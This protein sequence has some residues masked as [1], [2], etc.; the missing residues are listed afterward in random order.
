[1]CRY[2]WLMCLD[3]ALAKTVNP[4][5]RDWEIAIF[6]MNINCAGYGAWCKAVCSVSVS[7]SRRAACVWC[8]PWLS[9]I[10]TMKHSAG[11]Q[12]KIHRSASNLQG[13]ETCA[14]R[15]LK[16]Y[17]WFNGFCR[18]L[19]TICMH[20]I[21]KKLLVKWE[22]R[23]GWLGTWVGDCPLHLISFLLLW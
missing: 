5:V 8:W 3:L 10:R 14:L 23:L 9:N 22:V 4:H 6:V 2:T 1:M 20:H 18:R 13:L 16:P 11:C 17:S 19:Y 15:Q 7:A 21:F 12:S